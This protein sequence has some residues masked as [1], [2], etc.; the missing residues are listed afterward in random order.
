MSIG[1]LADVLRS[2]GEEDAAAAGLEQVT[3]SEVPAELV[4]DADGAEGVVFAASVD[5]YCGRAA[6]AEST[7]PRAHLPVRRDQDAAHP[8]LFEEVEV[9]GLA[10]DVLVAVAEDHGQPVLGGLA[11]RAAGEIGEERVAHIEHDEADRRAAPD[12]Q[13]SRRVVAHVPELVDRLRTRRTASG[14]TLS[15]WFSTLET[16]P[17]DTPALAATSRML[18]LIT[19]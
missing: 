8:L 13:L 5:E 3:R 2:A 16:V 15:R 1:D 10:V 14:E 9:A 19:S 12:T 4:V 7:Q 17:T 11:F 6:L 18:A